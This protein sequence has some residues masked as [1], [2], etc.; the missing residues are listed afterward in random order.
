MVCGL[1]GLDCV[2]QDSLQHQMEQISQANQSWYRQYYWSMMLPCRF[3]SP[4]NTAFFFLG[5]V[6]CCQ[7][8]RRWADCKL[9]QRMNV[10]DQS[11]RSFPYPFPLPCRG[12]RLNHIIS[13]Y[14][15]VKLFVVSSTK[16]SWQLLPIGIHLDYCQKLSKVFIVDLDD[17]VGYI[18][19]KF[20]VDIKL[21]Q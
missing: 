18:L 5:W 8:W 15:T 11:V 4:G 20:I 13:C 2:V 3:W 7:L 10:R 1:C 12:R 19:R 16:P 21:S 17:G 14:T 9:S 6:W